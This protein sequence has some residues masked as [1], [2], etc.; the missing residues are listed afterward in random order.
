[1]ETLELRIQKVI[2]TAFLSLAFVVTSLQLFHSYIVQRV[3]PK[4][5][6]SKQLSLYLDSPGSKEKIHSALIKRELEIIKIDEQKQKVTLEER[7]TKKVLFTSVPNESEILKLG[8][9][10][11]PIE[12]IEF[13]SPQCPHSQKLRQSMTKILAEFSDEI[14]YRYNFLIPETHRYGRVG[15]RMILAAR[16]NNKE[17][18]MLDAVYAH[19][20]KVFLDTFKGLSEELGLDFNT[21][22]TIYNEESLNYDQIIEQHARFASS[23][24]ILQV[25]ALFINGIDL[26]GITDYPT[27]RRVIES[28]LLKNVPD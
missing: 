4:Q 2:I 17:W 12:I 26:T 1:M 16:Q 14:H 11:A 5:S 15:A 9:T 18:E 25:P 22:L 3:T 27:I 7:L 8:T 10:D 24:D 6:F 19:Q 28:E 21:L 23:N 13:S 20:G